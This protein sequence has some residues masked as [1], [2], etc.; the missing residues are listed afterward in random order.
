M[1]IRG[2]WASASGGSWPSPAFVVARGLGR[3]RAEIGQAAARLIVVKVRPTDPRQ[4]AGVVVL[5]ERPVRPRGRHDGPGS[6]ERRQPER[7]VPEPAGRSG[8]L[9][10]PG[11]R[12]VDDRPLPGQR[13][14]PRG[15]PGDPGDHRGDADP[16]AVGGLLVGIVLQVNDERESGSDV[17]GAHGADR[18]AR[19]R[20]TGAAPWVGERV[21]HDPEP[22]RRGGT[23]VGRVVAIAVV[24]PF[25]DLDRDEADALPLV[26]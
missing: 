23:R 7:V 21:R 22:R 26:R 25:G 10:P 18:V 20:Q 14:G 2:A 8:A 13:V 1:P 9:P 6:A 16:V 12:R 19:R 15:E 11:G 24:G 17:R 5:P 3:G 4:E